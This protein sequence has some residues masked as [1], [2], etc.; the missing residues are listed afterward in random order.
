MAD[1]NDIPCPCGCDDVY[2]YEKKMGLFPSWKRCYACGGDMNICGEWDE[3]S[4]GCQKYKHMKYMKSNVLPL[5]K[6]N[7]K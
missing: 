5:I 1:S 7:V 6:I 2:M 3:N 4:D